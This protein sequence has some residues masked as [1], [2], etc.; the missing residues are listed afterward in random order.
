M[1]APLYTSLDDALDQIAPYGAE[2]KNGNSNHAP[3]V[4]EALCALGH[5]EAAPLWIMRYRER[6]QARPPAGEPIRGKDWRSAL[7]R[8][9]RFADWA[10]F[11]AGELENAAWPFVLDRWV[12][13]LAPGFCAAA[14]HGVIRVGHAVRGLADR[15]T[16]NRRRELADALATWAATWQQLP[17][18]AESVPGS[19]LP[20]GRVIAQLP[21]VPLEQRR[22]GNIVAAL[23]AVAD[24]P[25]FAPS[26]ATADLGGEAGARIAE[27]SE[28]FVRIY[29]A[30]AADI[31]RTIAFVH[32]VTSLAALGNIAPHVSEPTTRTALRYAWQTGCALYA[33]FGGVA[34][35]DSIAP[36][37]PSE[38]RVAERAI[39]NGDEH[40]IKF[41]EACRNRDAAAAS[42]A[43]AAA[44]THI[45]GMIRARRPIP[46]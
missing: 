26:V 38:E 11:F 42:P 27:L 29:L 44:I 18:L 25:G 16:P 24:L 31:P 3:M 5:P 28:L 40:V 46:A 33:C 41:T 30:N 21:V 2:L 37:D 19:V 39:A 20:P 9:D 15:E 10:A 17:A 8:R 22:A 43:Y 6:M 32:A 36:G 1:R 13:R 35:A 23:G 45:A 4:A 12:A 34:P 14:A 7:G